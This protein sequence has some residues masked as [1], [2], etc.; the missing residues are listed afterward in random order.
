MEFEQITF[1]NYLASPLEPLSFE[2]MEDIHEQVL[3]NADTKNEDFKEF[4]EETIRSVIAYS[5]IRAK[6]NLM[7]KNEKMEK[8]NSR[9]SA[10]DLVINNFIVLERIFK[11]NDWDSKTWTEKLF[12]QSDNPTR[13]KD[14]LQSVRKRIGDFANYLAFV[15]DLNGR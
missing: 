1:S 8:D 11:M 13:N 14:D 4:W 5:S 12:L 2:E 10:H 6:W 3:S 7:T 15:Y 9:T